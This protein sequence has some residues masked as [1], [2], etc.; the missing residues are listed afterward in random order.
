MSRFIDLT[1]R[2]FGRWTV[3]E[4][5][6]NNKQGATCWLCECSCEKHTRKVVIGNKLKDG[7]STSCGC[8][9]KEC[10]SKNFKKYNKYDLS[11]EYGVGWTS[12]TS[13]K[14]YFDLED[15]NKIK[16]Y[17]WYEND[18]GYI[19]AH[20]KNSKSVR[21]H[22][23]ITNTD[24]TTLI[25]HE[26]RN[27][28]DCRK[29][30]LRVCN[31]SENIRNRKTICTNTSG[32]IGVVKNKDKWVAQITVKDRNIYLG[33]FM[34]KEDAIKARLEA[35]LKYFGKDFAPQRHLFEQ[36]SISTI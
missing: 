3:I 1:G 6:N 33:I 36:Y 31:F 34:D 16:D 18:S 12:N 13:K 20:D 19:L 14:F 2:Q 21:L 17:C 15:Y 32:Y 27:K 35:E 30:N 24:K 23:L 28:N 9:Q 29:E 22:K 5:A 4:R 26:N 8:F 10:V 7:E 25:D 11:G